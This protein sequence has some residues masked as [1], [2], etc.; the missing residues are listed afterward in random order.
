MIRSSLF[1]CALLGFT[2]SHFVSTATLQM[3]HE[4]LANSPVG[5]ASK[6]PSKRVR[7]EF[8]AKALM[9]NARVLKEAEY[10]GQKSML[11]VLNNSRQQLRA[12]T[13][14]F[15]TKMKSYVRQVAVKMGTYDECPVLGSDARK[16]ELVVSK[17]AGCILDD[18]LCPE[19]CCG[20]IIE[21]SDESQLLICELEGW[22]VFIPTISFE[23]V[24]T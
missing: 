20:G 10:K 8:L 4:D 1:S 6:M 13:M 16:I 5:H 19:T 11:R 22:S 17:C 2:L 9:R 15:A 3:P 21:G 24:I 14:S 12:P 7:S 18:E 23:K